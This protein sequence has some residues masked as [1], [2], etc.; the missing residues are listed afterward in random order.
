[1]FAHIPAASLNEE[2]AMQTKDTVDYYT[3]S[4]CKLKIMKI[5]LLVMSREFSRSLM[6]QIFAESVAKT[7]LMIHSQKALSPHWADRFYNNVKSRKESSSIVE[8]RGQTDF[9]DNIRI[10]D[11]CVQHTIKHLLPVKS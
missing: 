5:L 2:A 6:C 11:E 7:F 9:Y 4:G 8:S 10:V 1:M 3:K